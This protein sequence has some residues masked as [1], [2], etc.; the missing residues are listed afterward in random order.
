MSVAPRVDP[1]LEEVLA[2]AR[3]AAALIRDVYA[4]PFEVEMKGP[5]DP[6]TAAD[7]GAND[8]ICE[9]LEARFP[10]AS[11][12][13]EESA[14]ASGDRIADLVRKERIFFVDPLDGTREFAARN[15]E[16]AV[17]IGLVAGGRPTLGVILLPTTGDALVARVGGACF[18]EDAT[19]RRAPLAV[20][21]E[22]DPASARL[23]VSRARPPRVLSPIKAALGITR[24]LVCGSVGA[25]VARVARGEAELYVHGGGGAKRWDTCAPE[26][27]VIA[28]GGRFTDLD[29]AL[30]DYGSADL[31]IRTGIVASNGLFH[32]R[33]VDVARAE[34]RRGSGRPAP[35]DAQGSR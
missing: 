25:K 5:G 26:A 16:F 14:P 33:V 35:G 31:T 28:A 10:D 13:A 12:V 4:T 1:E 15:G 9:R 27:V 22:R 32:D 6:V 21:P 3:D 19:G 34:R 8:L 23:M 11:I 17:M 18:V 24:E 29:G 20:S 7:R 2:I 30:I